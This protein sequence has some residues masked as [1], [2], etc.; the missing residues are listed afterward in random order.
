MA[1]VI[2]TRDG[3]GRVWCGLSSLSLSFL[4][5]IF[6]ICQQ[7]QKSLR[8]RWVC[9]CFPVV[10]R[11]HQDCLGTSSP[12]QACASERLSL[13]CLFQAGAQHRPEFSSSLQEAH[14]F[15]RISQ[16]RL[17]LACGRGW[18]GFPQAGVSPPH[19]SLGTPACP[20]H[21]SAWSCFPS[22]GWGCGPW[23]TGHGGDALKGAFGS[24]G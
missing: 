1:G 15:L 3:L 4:H 14:E 23:D 17:N 8:H 21:L 10:A 13:C 7:K 16:V 22:S 24:D 11:R 19:L 6:L 5:H 12:V 9:S 2:W 18:W 20:V